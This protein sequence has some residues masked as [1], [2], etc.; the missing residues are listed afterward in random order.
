MAGPG[1][2]RLCQVG[3]RT[4]LALAGPGMGLG[5]APAAWPGWEPQCLSCSWPR[6]G[7]PDVLQQA[8]GAESPNMGA[9][10]QPG[11]MPV[12]G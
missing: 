12:P 6:L 3:H 11:G 1:L 7:D 5:A 4:A 2:W 9:V 8:K 10:G